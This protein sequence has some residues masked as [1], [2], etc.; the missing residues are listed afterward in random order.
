M[1]FFSSA[2]TVQNLVRCGLPSARS[3]WEGPVW[4]R[5]LAFVDEPHTR[6]ARFDSAH[7][8]RLSVPVFCERPARGGTSTRVRIVSLRLESFQVGET[9]DDGGDGGSAGAVRCGGCPGLPLFVVTA[10]SS[11]PPGSGTGPPGSYSVY[12]SMKIFSQCLE[13]SEQLS[14]FIFQIRN[15]F[16]IC[17]HASSS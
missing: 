8:A 2:Q 17:L 6:T 9:E 13:S 5:G 3:Q 14:L 10:S 16:F 1:Y 7:A 12:G 4:S 11:S 15:P